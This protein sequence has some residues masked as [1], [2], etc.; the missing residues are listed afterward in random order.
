MNVMECIK[1]RRSVRSFEDKEVEEEKLAQVLE[2]AR[3]A[4]SARNLQEWKFIVVRDAKLR[5]QLA[6]AAC[7]QGFVGEAPVVIVACAVESGHIMTCGHPSHLIDIAIA[8]DHMTLAARE[9]GLG[10][11]WIG[12]FHQDKV[13]RA[14]GIP[15]SV[16]V[17][18]LL[19]LG[20]PAAWPEARPRKGLDDIV[21]YDRWEQQ[22]RPDG[23]A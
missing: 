4:P 6:E 12:A 3:L 10:T 15:A 1:A 21:C 14:L 18:Q 13:R 8:V 20:Y 2:A 23:G 7:G 16:Q 5:Q 22:V 11:C 17:V 9:L 19:P